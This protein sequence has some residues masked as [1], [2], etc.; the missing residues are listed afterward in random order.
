[1]K[2]FAFFRLGGTLPSSAARRARLSVL[3]GVSIAATIIVAACGSSTG[4]DDLRRD[5]DDASAGFGETDGGG[6]E[7][8]RCV[9]QACAEAGGQCDGSS[10]V[11]KE[12]VGGVS[13]ET[14]AALDGGGNADA[15][16]AWLYPYDKT[17]FPRGLIPPTLQ[18]S[19]AGVDALYVRIRVEGIDYR[20]YFGASKPPRVSLPE[21][22]WNVVTLAAK[23]TSEV[24]VEVTKSEGGKITG[25]IAETWRIA[26]GSLAGTIYY[27]T[28]N[29]KLIGGA[30]MPSPL[31]PV[32]SGVGI[33]K[34]EPGA[35]EPTILK[36]GCANVCH[37][38]SSD[39]STLVA[40]VELVNPDVNDTKNQKYNSKSAVYDLRNGAT[41]IVKSETQVFTYGALTPDGK[42]SMMA[43]NYR[44]SFTDP[45]IAGAALTWSQLYDTH[46]GKVV[47]TVGWA[48]KN[49]GVPA[50]SPD[51]KR[52]AF[53]NYDTHPLGDTLTVV[54]FDQTLLTFTSPV[55]VVTVTR[56]NETST[57]ENVGWPAFT[58]DS[59]TVV[60]QSGVSPW[61]E[62]HDL[63]RADVYGVDVATKKE[64]CLYALNGYRSNGTV[65][66][67]ATD[68]QTNFAPTILPVAVG[69]YYW[70]VFTSHRSYGN[71]LESKAG[72]NRYGKLWVAA[73]DIGGNLDKDPSHPAFY[74]DGQEIEADNLRGFWVLSPCKDDGKDCKDGSECCGGYCRSVSGA[75]VCVLPPDSCANESEK[76]VTSG[77][78]CTGGSLCINGRCTMPTPN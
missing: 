67:P 34:I 77:D 6:G 46:T 48:V 66:L 22:V 23:A 35:K 73:M 16:F 12:F 10:C 68:P 33:M 31:G 1:M 25:P 2:P 17:V 21:K 24:K 71:I 53:I 37:T 51:G 60:Y 4:D 28:Y 65:Y 52:L 59:K 36:K 45:S 38:A 54:N 7:P 14:Q 9:V 39:G 41:Q 62:T 3:F 13:S 64:Q 49:P 8:A 26:Q 78:C 56:K 55:D 57:N 32:A 5:G 43:R 74:L 69:G 40:S 27:E 11:I 18:F 70:V 29:S 75:P 50:F 63:N 42:Y 61:Y 30:P 20:G 58:P 47:P 72:N 19:G 44:T 76:C 15:D